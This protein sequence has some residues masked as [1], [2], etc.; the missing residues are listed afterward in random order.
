MRW[1]LKIGTIAGTAIRVHM[2]FIILLV[3]IWL[4]HYQI[5]G[6]RA[7]WDGLA[8][9]VAV[10]G[11]VLLH[12]F[13][14]IAVA[15]RFGIKTPE[16]MLL[17]IGGVA[18][19]ERLPKEP[20][21]EMLIAIAG[22]LVNLA[23]TALIMV[24]IGGTGSLDQAFEPQDP[25]IGFLVRLAGVNIFLMLFNL[26][27]AF[28]MDGGRVL[29]AILCLWLP[30][31]RATQIA[32]AIGQGI[33]LA[34]GLFGLLFNPWLIVIAVF[35]YLAATSEER[36]AQIEDL[37]DHV[38]V[39]DVMITEFETLS[40]SSSIEEA[41]DKLLATT[42]NDFPVVGSDGHLVG[43]LNRNSIITALKEQGPKTPVAQAMRSDIPEIGYR[44]PLKEGLGRMREEDASV[45]AVVDDAGLLCGLINYE[46]IG[47]ILMVRSA[48]SG[49]FKLGHLRHVGLKYR[50]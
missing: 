9:I 6:A 37:A 42:Q 17:P 40:R 12:E 24:V 4:A 48:A 47:E 36:D 43:L 38:C 19:L 7:A 34:L 29:R 16:I 5:S 28:P 31:V 20:R 25:R 8:F 18:T 50:F 21:Q 32:A 3:W 35:V 41:V 22:P 49:D 23:I 30:W 15:R 45:V 46:T 1:S 13:G 39:S 44:A 33:A 26:I 27:P 10:F 2:T 14:H 11:C